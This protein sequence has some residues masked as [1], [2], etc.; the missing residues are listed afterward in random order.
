MEGGGGGEGR[1]GGRGREISVFV[2]H[3]V[4]VAKS[5]HFCISELRDWWIV[6][7]L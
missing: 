4:S 6:S 1:G 7:Q 2:A 5:T 3:K